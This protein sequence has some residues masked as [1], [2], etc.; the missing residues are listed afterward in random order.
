[1][2]NIDMP[3][4]PRVRL[5]TT[6]DRVRAVL[7]LLAEQHGPHLSAS[8]RELAIAADTRS[9]EVSRELAKLQRAGIIRRNGPGD[10]TVLDRSAL[11]A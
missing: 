1:M 2:Y 4:V 10:L 6:G 7:R 5:F 11:E 8:T 3:H 9:E